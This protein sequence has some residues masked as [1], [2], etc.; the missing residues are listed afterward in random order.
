VRSL[1][2]DLSG[3]HVTA[4]CPRRG[5]NGKQHNRTYPGAGPGELSVCLSVCLQLLDRAL[6]FDLPTVLEE[7]PEERCRAGRAHRSTSLWV[8]VTVKEG[9]GRGGD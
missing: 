7:H 2:H 9:E 6:L 4:G 5:G 1:A 3:K 8:T